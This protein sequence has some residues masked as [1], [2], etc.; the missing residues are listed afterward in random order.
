M[1]LYKPS[2]LLKPIFKFAPPK[3]KISKDESQKEDKTKH[4]GKD[5]EDAYLTKDE[6][7]KILMEYV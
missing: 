5:S 2:S 3:E 1:E 7:K 6:V 4:E